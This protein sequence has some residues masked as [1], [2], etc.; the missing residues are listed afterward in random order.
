MEV[1]SPE[2]AAGKIL[3]LCRLVNVSEAELSMSMLAN[4]IKT[5]CTC[6]ECFPIWQFLNLLLLPFMRRTWLALL[7]HV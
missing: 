5:C 7:G 3:S 1:L 2:N 4:V 6:G